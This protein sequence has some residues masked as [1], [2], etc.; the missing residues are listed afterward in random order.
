MEHFSNKANTMKN[1]ATPQELLAFA[2]WIYKTF[3]GM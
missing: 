1:D 2:D 3:G